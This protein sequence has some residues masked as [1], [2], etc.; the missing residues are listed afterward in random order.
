M[1]R[2]KTYEWIPLWVEK[3]LWGSTRIELTPAERSV[4][5][6]LMVLGSKDDG[7]IRA[8]PTT[9]YQ[10]Q[11]LAGM[12]CLEAT[13]LQSAVAQCIQYGKLEKDEHGC[14]RIVNW[15]AYSLGE[16]YKRKLMADESAPKG[17][18]RG[19]SSMYMSKSKSSYICFKEGVWGNI[20]A[21]NMK[22]W[23]E[24]YPACDLKIELAKMRE[25]L[26]ANPT[27]AVKSNWRRF[28]TNWL[29]RSQDRGGTIRTVGKRGD[30][31][32]AAIDRMKLTREK[33]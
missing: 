11:Q 2:G 12:L 25:W 31:F 7:Y 32:E 21:D 24:A 4:W 5:V 15:E 19:P 17:R 14:L 16:R 33:P 10:D 20:T 13:L 22:S 8:N 1:K 3:W 26:I 23:A 18:I 28:I 27:K 6:D 29:S 30:D 9:P